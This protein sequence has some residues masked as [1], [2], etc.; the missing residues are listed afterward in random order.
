MSLMKINVGQINISSLKNKIDEVKIMVK[1][2]KL[3]VLAVCETHLSSIFSNRQI[4]INGYKTIPRDRLDGRKGGGCVVYVSKELTAVHLKQLERDGI[5][6]IWLR[7]VTKSCSVVVGS[8]YRPPNNMAF[9]QDI[10]YPLEKAWLKYKNLILLGDFNVNFSKTASITD[11]A[12]QDKFLAILTQF[13]YSVVNTDYTRV[14][15]TTA[16]TIDL[17]IANKG[18]IVENIKTADIGNFDHNL[19]SFTLN[20]QVKK[21]PPKI[22]TIRTYKNFNTEKS[23]RDLQN[24]PYWPTCDIFDEIDD[25]YSTWTDILKNIHDEHAPK[26]R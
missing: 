14:T 3:D 2:N 10:V 11:L 15:S 8:F 1:T 5:E 9:F 6:A 16:T 20:L 17:I 4:Q 25:K 22:I 7:I 12:L 18:K 13:D 26:N 23:K 19:V 24:A 21:Q